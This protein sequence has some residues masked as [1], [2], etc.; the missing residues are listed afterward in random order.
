MN[1][2]PGQ[3]HAL[4][5]KTFAIFLK[6]VGLRSPQYYEDKS[7]CVSFADIRPVERACIKALRLK[8]GSIEPADLIK[9]LQQLKPSENFEFREYRHPHMS[10]IKPPLYRSD[11]YPPDLKE[12]PPIWRHEIWFRLDN[13]LGYRR[14][15]PFFA[16]FKEHWEKIELSLNRTPL[17][18]LHL[19]KND[20]SSPNGTIYPRYLVQGLHS[21]RESVEDKVQYIYH[22]KV[23]KAK[24][25]K[26]ESG[27]FG[28]GG[29]TSGHQVDQR[30]YLHLQDL[31]FRSYGYIR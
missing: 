24:Q 1:M 22:K 21:L 5:M 6:D 25:T 18:D 31:A 28:L 12:D 7:Q 30:P 2:S 17:P 15:E 23:R 3:G 27:G 20:G 8:W 9:R 14:A 11:E 29:K 13:L 26:S 19:L 16:W 4:Y 10:W